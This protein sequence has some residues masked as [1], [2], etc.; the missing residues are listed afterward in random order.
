[1]KTEIGKLYIEKVD[2]IFMS[3]QNKK[4]FPN[5]M[6]SCDHF[7]VY[8]SQSSLKPKLHSMTGLEEKRGEKREEKSIAPLKI[9]KCTI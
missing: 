1:L 6:L 9:S 8:M 3:F 5:Y 2:K 7:M 4:D